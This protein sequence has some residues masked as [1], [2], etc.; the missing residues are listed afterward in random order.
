MEVSGPR[1]VER[2]H[3]SV[4][5]QPPLPL[6]LR[7]RLPQRTASPPRV[8]TRSRERALT[9]STPSPNRTHDGHGSENDRGRSKERPPVVTDDVS[10]EMISLMGFSGFGSTKGKHVAGTKG[11]GVRQNKKLNYRQYMNR[12]K[13][14]NRALSPER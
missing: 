2:L 7:S 5:S 10:A 1:N 14:F 13:G 11:G 6:K 3:H 4:S 9:N 12:D 8:R